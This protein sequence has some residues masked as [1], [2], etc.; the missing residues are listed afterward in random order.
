ML[1]LYVSDHPLMGAEA[2]LRRR[3]DCSIADLEDQSADGGI[4]VIGGV[5]T[6]L[7]RKWTR[8]GDLMAVFVLED[9]QASIEVMVFPKTMAEHGQKLTDDAVVLAKGRYDTRDDSPKFIAMEIEVFE[10]VDDGSRPLEIKLPPSSVTDAL[11]D[12]LKDV[13]SSH[14]GHSRVLLHVGAQRVQLPEG[15][16]TGNGLV[17][18]LREM[19]GVDSVVTS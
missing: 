8:K 19:L 4:R 11:V 5:I 3:V 18:E 6:S 9:L 15:V 16:D 14:P 1:G 10:P 7:Q 12:R 2:S 13:L 17:A